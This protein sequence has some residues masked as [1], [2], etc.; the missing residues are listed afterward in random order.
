MPEPSLICG[1]IY[2]LEIKAFIETEHILYDLRV[3]LVGSADNELG[4]AFNLRKPHA[5]FCKPAHQLYRMENVF[6]VILFARKCRK[7]FPARSLDIKRHRSCKRKGI[8]NRCIGS[9]GG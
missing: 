5:L 4:G 3:S 7:V 9:S 6:I 1:K 2:A 8:L